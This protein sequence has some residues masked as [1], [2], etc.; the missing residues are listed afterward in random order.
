MTR[1]YYRAEE[2]RKQIVSVALDLVSKHGVKEATLNRIAQG[3]GITTPALYGHFASRKDILLEV[4]ENVFE[5]VRELHR[6][7]KNPNAL[8]RLREIGLGHTRLVSDK[9]GFALAFFEFIAAPPDEDLRE[10]LGQKE[11]TLV[12]DLVEIVKEGQSQGTIRRDIDPYQIAWMIVSR[13]WTEDIAYLMGIVDHWSPTRSKWML[14][15]IL[16]LIA[17][18]Q[19]PRPP[20]GR[21]SVRL[22]V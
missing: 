10:A 22:R 19:V 18:P 11:L 15:H 5:N 17:A 2:R 13:A 7:A 1:P 9:E 20:T 12:E 4:M 21:D 8:E 3:V 16:D 6:S 14:E